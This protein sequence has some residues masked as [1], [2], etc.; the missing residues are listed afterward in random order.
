METLGEHIRRVR[1]GKDYSLREFAKKL[2][3]TA[4]FL[5]DIERNKRH[6][7]ESVLEKIARWLDLDFEDLK[8]LDN[9]I[10]IKELKE[11]FD[12]NND[13]GFAFRKLAQSRV[14]PE[15]L[16]RL[17]QEKDEDKSSK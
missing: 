6:P 16:I 13:Y 10:P 5:S 12:T 9:R 2:E 7:S 14:T 11:L 1:E 8:K 4:T 3:V 15:Q 17:A